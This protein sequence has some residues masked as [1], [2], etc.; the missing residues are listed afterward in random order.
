MK[1]DINSLSIA[2]ASYLTF[3]VIIYAYI[4]RNRYIDLALA[5]IAVFS[6]A[7][8]MLLKGL[9]VLLAE[10]QALTN[11]ATAIMAI[12]VVLFIGRYVGYAYAAIKKRFTR[13]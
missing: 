8:A 6:F 2:L 11:L 13:R 1:I 3:A 7:S 10:S 12:A 5:S 9:G 4:N